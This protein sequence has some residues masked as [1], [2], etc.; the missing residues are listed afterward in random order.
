M[1]R[2]IVTVG[3]GGAGRS[4]R[5][6]TSVPGQQIIRRGTEGQTGTGGV[7]NRPRGGT[8]SRPSKTAT[9]LMQAN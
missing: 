4:Q 6:R 2:L 7:N 5:T 3:Y 1:N 8:N 9:V